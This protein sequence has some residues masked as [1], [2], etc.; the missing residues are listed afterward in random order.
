MRRVD[1][2]RDT[3][4]A[5]GVIIVY[6]S[7]SEGAAATCSTVETGRFEGALLCRD[8]RGSCL[9]VVGVAVVT[10]GAQ[11][12]LWLA[13]AVRQCLLLGRFD[14]VAGASMGLRIVVAWEMRGNRHLTCSEF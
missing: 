14:M 2:R 7:S 12:S 3:V 13:L 9:G 10:T 6:S 4:V 1:M 5:S 11:L 8:R